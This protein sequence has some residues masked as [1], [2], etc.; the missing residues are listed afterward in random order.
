[1]K[2]LL[3]IAGII[4]GAAVAWGLNKLLAG[5][6]ENKGRRIGLQASAYI[7]FILLGL[8]FAAVFSLRI[9]LDKF[10]DNRIQAIEVKLDKTFP[11]MNLLETRLDTG[12]LVSINDQIQQS[13]K[14][15]DTESDGFFEKLVFNALMAKLSSSINAVDTGVNALSNMSDDDGSMT[16]KTLLYNLK[17][18]ALN[19][20]SPYF[21]VFQVL[22]LICA[23]IFIGIYAAIVVS[24]RNEEQNGAKN[25]AMLDAALKWE[26][27]QQN[28]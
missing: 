26:K 1:M 15:I 17:D 2:V 4:A 21:V 27:E 22:I 19:A 5:K 8:A 25:A 11:N 12:E 24:V 7:V 18:T 9:V 3:I 23:V 13:I 28:N 16:I 10:I 6:I 20:A 14:D